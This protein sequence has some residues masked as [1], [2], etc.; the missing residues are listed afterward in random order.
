MDILTPASADTV[1]ETVNNQ[2][3]QMES[4]ANQS[5]NNGIQ[6]YVD[7][8]YKGAALAF[9]RAFGL[10]PYS[11]YAVDSAKY[12]AMSQI[13]LGETNNAIQTYNQAIQ[14]HPNDDT[15]Y[16]ALGNLYFGEE[17]TGEAITA[18]E[19]AVRIYDD[20]NNRFSLGQAYLKSGRNE[21]A[22]NQF[23]KVIELNQSSANGYFGLGQALAAQKKYPE[24]IKQFE[25]AVQKDKKFYDAYAEMGY[26]YADAGNLD[27]AKDIQKLLEDKKSSLADTLD[28]YI[29]KMTQP[30]ILFAWPDGTFPYF[31]PLKTEVAGLNDYM[32]NAN[33]SRSFSMV[34]QFNKSMDRE[35]V[36]NPL[37]WTITRASGGGPGMDYNFGLGIPD[38][39]ALVSTYPSDI[40][41][42]EKY[43][44]AIVRFTV[45]QNAE[46]TATIDPSHLQFTFKGTDG[47][48]NTMHPKYDQ[49]MGFS[50]SF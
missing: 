43:Y 40:Y 46:G 5:L 38:T 20:G 19:N 18:Y 8:D 32:A 47:D 17:K 15:L 41:Y 12:L 27:K 39:E 37:N 14:L 10:A 21:D 33:A 24:A 34:F 11:D 4:L 6:K 16:T 44:N 48:G 45:N 29:Q 26:T 7:K 13:K 31:M 3:T 35:S 22:A 25:R 28:K 23:R 49:Y 2:S 9:K 1:F 30:E 36:E 50:G 42:D